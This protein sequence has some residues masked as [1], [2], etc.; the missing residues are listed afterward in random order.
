[1]SKMAHGIKEEHGLTESGR[2]QA[3]EAGLK[4][5][6]IH[7]GNSTLICY[8]SP[9]SRTTETAMLAMKAGQKAGLLTP[10]SQCLIASD[11]LRERDFGT[12][13]EGQP[14]EAVYRQ[15]WDYDIVSVDSKADDGESLL[16]VQHRCLGFINQLEEKHRG[17][18]LAI[19][20]VSHG[21]TLSILESSLLGMDIRRHRDRAYGTGE[22]R[23]LQSEFTANLHRR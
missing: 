12:L 20:L 22:L 23:H 17:Q 10:D 13:N 8:H 21:D 15:T 4:L 16:D 6:E 9:F 18:Q 3:T 7:F 1:M 19:L 11:A 2:R 5:K 14:S